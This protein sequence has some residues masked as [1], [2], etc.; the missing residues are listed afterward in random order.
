MVLENGF[1]IYKAAKILGINH[2]TAK[3]I[4]RKYRKNGSIFCRKMEE[5]FSSAA[6]QSVS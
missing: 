3:A 5:S 1:S 4:M 6:F 2:S